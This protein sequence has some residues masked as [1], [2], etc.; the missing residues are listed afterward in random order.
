MSVHTFIQ[1]FK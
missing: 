1:D